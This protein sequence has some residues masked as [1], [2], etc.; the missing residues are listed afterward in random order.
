VNIPIN[1]HTLAER[2]AKE[3]AKTEA[4]VHAVATAVA[5][6]KVK[7]T[8]DP[9]DEGILSLNRG[10]AQAI[11]H[12]LEAQARRLILAE[13]EYQKQGRIT[14]SEH[15][16]REIALVSEL[17]VIMKGFLSFKEIENQKIQVPRNI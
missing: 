7:L 4:A 3:A 11:A 16:L 12:E 17:V 14:L 5:K 2:T 8:K 1:E 9:G 15:T 13:T 6:A 10:Q